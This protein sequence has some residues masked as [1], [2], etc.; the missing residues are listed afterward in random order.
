M[1]AMCIVDIAQ[2]LDVEDDD[3][4]GGVLC[5]QLA[6]TMLQMLAEEF[7]LRKRYAEGFC[8]WSTAFWP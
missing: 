8:P 6:Q 5:D 2:A 3:S 4:R 7:P 1:A